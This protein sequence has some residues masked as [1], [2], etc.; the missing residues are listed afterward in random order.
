MLS[1]VCCGR[2]KGMRGRTRQ[3]QNQLASHS[4]EMNWRIGELASWRAGE[5]A[6]SRSQGPVQPR[7]HAAGKL[8]ASSSRAGA[9]CRHP[10]ASW[11]PDNPDAMDLR[12]EVTDPRSSFFLRCAIA[13]PPKPIVETSP[14]GGA[15][16]PALN[17]GI[18]ELDAKR[19][20]LVLLVGLVQFGL[21]LGCGLFGGAGGGFRRRDRGSPTR[22]RPRDR[23]EPHVSV[24][25]C[26]IS[27]S[28]IKFPGMHAVADNVNNAHGNPGTAE[29]EAERQRRTAK[30]ERSKLVRLPCRDRHLGYPAR[31]S[32]IASEGQEEE[33]KRK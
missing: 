12:L 27:L 17:V 1:A 26:A 28:R 10:V 23:A 22:R 21:M 29:A 30:G 11:Y 3:E 6:S 8:E 15:S 13:S 18:K 32:E 14:R 5:L 25:E 7:K 4:A 16:L 24:H 19:F 2:S 31:P 9:T 33:G 20:L